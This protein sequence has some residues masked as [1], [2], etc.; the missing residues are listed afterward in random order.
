MASPSSLSARR[1]PAPLPVPISTLED[2]HT[3]TS[4]GKIGKRGRTHF[5]YH[6]SFFIRRR[7]AQS[8]EGAESQ[9]KIQPVS[10]SYF[11]GS[12]F[13]SSRSIDEITLNYAIR[14]DFSAS[15]RLGVLAVIACKEK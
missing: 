6:F 13:L 15:W 12:F 14:F 9:R 8:R 10:L 5:P 4:K 11:R 2:R 3:D 7:P 1:Y